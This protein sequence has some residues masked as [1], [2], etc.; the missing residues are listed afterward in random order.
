M[1]HELWK[2][3]K[4]YDDI[5]MVSNFGRVKSIVY[6]SEKILKPRISG[7]GYCQVALYKN[8]KS[9]NFTVHRLVAENF[10]DNPNE[11]KYINHKDENKLNNKAENLEWCSAF[12]NNTYG[13]RMGKVK[14]PV[15]MYKEGKLLKTYKSITEAS[16]CHNLTVGGIS[17][18]CR[19]IYKDCG[20]YQWKYL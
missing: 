18:C 9:K 10:I 2:P 1:Q 15:G 20:G 7:R 17:R 11:Y 8:G 6:T 19:G 16:K 14:K 5:Y 4:G 12:Y 13:T 3:I